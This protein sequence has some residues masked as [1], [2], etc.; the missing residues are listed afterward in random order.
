MREGAPERVPT[1]L[2]P[3]LLPLPLE[4]ACPLAARQ[5]THTEPSS[6]AEGGCMWIVN[7]AAV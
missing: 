3:R 2:L 4:F 6:E 7:E 1:S 5:P